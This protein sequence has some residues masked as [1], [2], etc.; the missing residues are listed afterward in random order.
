M[1][2]FLNMLVIEL[3]I[4]VGETLMEKMWSNRIFLV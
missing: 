2:V 1:K 3:I 4:A